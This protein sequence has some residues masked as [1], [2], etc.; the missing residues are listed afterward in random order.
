V[1]TSVDGVASF[2]DI[3][4]FHSTT[5][6][7]KKVVNLSTLT[8]V[9]SGYTPADGSLTANTAVDGLLGTQFRVKYATARTYAGGTSLAV[10][11][12]ASGGGLVVM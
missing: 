6:S 12:V 10:D 7:L 8:P 5:G 1:Q 3:A 11:V 9:T 2:T 4:N